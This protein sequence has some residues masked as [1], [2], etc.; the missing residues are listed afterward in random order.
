MMTTDDFTNREKKEQTKFGLAL[1]SVVI[2]V[3]LIINLETHY[4]DVKLA[5]KLSQYYPVYLC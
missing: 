3:V 4:A 2:L 1:F 5:S